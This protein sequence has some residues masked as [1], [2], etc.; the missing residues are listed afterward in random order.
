[1]KSFITKK[2]VRNV[3][4]KVNVHSHI[5]IFLT[6]SAKGISLFSKHFPFFLFFICLMQDIIMYQKAAWN[7][8][9]KCKKCVNW[10]TERTIHLPVF[11]SP[12]PSQRFSCCIKNKLWCQGLNCQSHSGY[13]SWH[14]CPWSTQSQGHDGIEGQLLSD[15]GTA[16]WHL[17]LAASSAVWRGSCSGGF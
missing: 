12:S 17:Q 6:C 8:S 10:R 13:V 3:E 15:T 7:Y 11:L 14:K 16:A 5:F 9:S 2:N 4:N 1:M